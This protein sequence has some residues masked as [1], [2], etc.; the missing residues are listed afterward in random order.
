MNKKLEFIASYTNLTNSSLLLFGVALCFSIL[1]TQ[2]SLAQDEIVCEFLD[3][4]QNTELPLSPPT[5][6]GVVQVS[7]VDPGP[8][9]VLDDGSPGVLGNIRNITY[10]PI[11]LFQNF[12]ATSILRIGELP[13]GSISN[14]NGVNGFAPFSILYNANGEGLDLDL[15]RTEF[16]TLTVLSNDQPNTSATFVLT[17]SINNS[18][19]Y[20]F[21]NLPSNLGGGTLPAEIDFIISEFDGIEFINLSNIRSIE[22]RS[23]PNNFGSDIAFLPIE[24]CGT[25]PPPPPPVRNI[26]TLS[27]WGLIAMAGL[28]G[29]VGYMVMRRRKVA[30]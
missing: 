3:S 12:S 6:G 23:A 29:I 5:P 21:F 24:I 19:E 30:V 1:I 25:P 11:N 16:I 26:P 10:G 18:A 15:S 2:V 20:T 9:N 7:K 4:F 27:E 14:S 17:D 28:F 8:V 22:F 13:D